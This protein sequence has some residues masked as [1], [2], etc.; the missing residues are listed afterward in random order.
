MCGIAGIV[1]LGDRP[2]PDVLELMVGVLVHRGP[3]D[4]G[5]HADQHAGIGMRRLSIIGVRNGRQPILNEDGSIALVLNGEIYNH[6]SLRRTLKSQGH[7]FRTD[8]DAEVAVHLFEMH[9]VNFVDHLHGMFALA[10]YDRTNRRVILAR[11]RAGKKPLYYAVSDGCLLFGSEIKAIHASGLLPKE[12]DTHSLRSFL[13]YGYVVGEG[14]MFRDIRKLPAGNRLEISGP[15]TRT[16]CYWEPPVVQTTDLSFDEAAVRLREMLEESVRKRLMSEVPL[17]AFLSGGIDS[18]AIVGIMAKLLRQPFHTFCVGFEDGPLEELHND[19]AIADHYG[20]L[21]H[22][23]LLKGCSLEL[24][25]DVNYFNDDPV[26]DPAV[27]PTFCLAHFARR[28]IKVA[29]TGEGGDEGFGGYRHYE[30]CRR[31][32]QFTGG[33]PGL[34]LAAGMIS[35]LQTSLQPLAPNLPWKGLWIA[36]L[37]AGEQTRGWLS[38]FTDVEIERLMRRGLQRQDGDSTLVREFRALQMRAGE[39][40]PVSQL[41]YVDSRSSLAD[42]LLMKV[43]KMT[44]A[45]SLEARCPLLDQELLEFAFRLPASMKLSGEGSK[46]VLR[47]A[48]EQIVPSETLQRRKQG[49]DPPLDR[50]LQT[51]MRPFVESGLLGTVSPLKPYLDL[52][53]VRGM[54]RRSLTAPQ[55]LAARQLWRIVN[56]AVW[57]ELHWPTGLLSDLP[58]P[59]SPV[60]DRHRELFVERGATVN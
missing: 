8:S 28:H 33:V 11:D 51:D 53:M 27:L 42:E 14:S 30:R 43:D 35:R 34:S 56:L 15:H 47:R 29:L 9:G 52:E 13:S 60:G 39:R 58:E 49:F 20:T 48:V 23:L 45:S 54:W 57:L 6:E 24:L 1:S 12:V 32:S 16:V 4:V 38:V 40:D 37:P 59:S 50:W 41:M 46:L 44:M 7:T 55:S 17:G 2:I 5:F 22:E 26:G 36:G 31:L 21:H 3:D 18:S 25:R 19:R 10:L